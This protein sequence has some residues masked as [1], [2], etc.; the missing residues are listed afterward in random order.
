MELLY[1][2]SILGGLDLLLQF[3]QPAD[4]KATG[5][6]GKIC[7][8]FSDLGLDHLRHKVGDGAGRIELTGGTCALQLL[9]NGLV[10]L[11]EGVAF[12]VVAEVELVD[13]VDDLPQQHAVLHV[14]VGIGKGG[15]HDCL[16]DGSGCV[17]RQIFQCREQLVVDKVQQFIA[18]QGGAGLIIVCPVLPAAFGSGMMD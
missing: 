14:V 12:L 1:A 6:A 7:H 5:A 8:R 2:S 9:Q 18:G 11:P 16:F 3:F 15:L 10:N 4:D 17:H 13:H